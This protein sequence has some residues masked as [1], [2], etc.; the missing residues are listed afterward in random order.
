[1]RLPLS[2]GYLAMTEREKARNNRKCFPLTLTLSLQ[3]KEGRMLYAPTQDRGNIR[4]FFIIISYGCDY[5]MAIIRKIIEK[6]LIFLSYSRKTMI[7]YKNKL[8]FIYCI[9]CQ[10]SFFFGRKVFSCQ[11]KK[12]GSDESDPYLRDCFVASQWQ[13]KIDSHFRGNDI[14]GSWDCFPCFRMGQAYFAPMTEG[15]IPAFAG[16]T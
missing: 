9:A 13:E 4:E 7:L 16:M 14:K 11:K 10:K 8:L 2:L 3:D 1:M 15:W 12:D 5:C 6:S